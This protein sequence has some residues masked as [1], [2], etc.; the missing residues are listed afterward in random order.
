MNN[1]DLILK[2]K[3]LL[4]ANFSVFPVNNKKRPL[5][6][7]KKQQTEAYSLEEFEKKCNFSKPSYIGYATGF[8]DI[9][10]IDVDLK[11]FE[12]LKEQQ[13]FWKDLHGFLR[14]NII[15]F[16]DKVAIYKTIN[17][18]YHIIYKAKNLE[19]NLKLAK[20][21]DYKEAIIETRGKGGY[22]IAYDN[23]VSK[24]SYKEVGYISE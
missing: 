22:C 2:G 17:N 7:W 4:Q 19:G 14:E 11:I 12:S 9:E 23:K 20:L 13:D 8:N 15:D 18:G 5:G 6:T 3:L 16:N 1:Q 10:V 24:K 21:K